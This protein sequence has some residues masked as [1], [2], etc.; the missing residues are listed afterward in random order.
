MNMMLQCFV[1]NICV[2]SQPTKE[3]TYLDAAGWV[4]RL[5]TELRKYLPGILD[6]VTYYSDK[7]NSAYDTTHDS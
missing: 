2:G 1:S 7:T 6:L 4:Q 3:Q 5:P